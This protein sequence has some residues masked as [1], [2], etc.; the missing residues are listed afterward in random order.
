MIQ[1]KGYTTTPIVLKIS[2]FRK[3]WAE[4]RILELKFIFKENPKNTYTYAS[5]KFFENSSTNTD[6]HCVFPPLSPWTVHWEINFCRCLFDV[7]LSLLSMTSHSLEKRNNARGQGIHIPW[8]SLCCVPQCWTASER[9][10]DDQ[11]LKLHN[12]SRF[13]D[14]LSAPMHWL[15]RKVGTKLLSFKLNFK[16]C[17]ETSKKKFFNFKNPTKGCTCCFGPIS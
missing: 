5:N 8:S 10:S 16:S 17:I 15:W 12:R 14:F 11:I 4:L 3:S 7:F 13:I 1:I 2:V 6:C 9:N